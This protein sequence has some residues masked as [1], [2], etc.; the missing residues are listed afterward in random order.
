MRSTVSPISTKSE[1][2]A[3]ASLSD[4]VRARSS[5]GRVSAIRISRYCFTAFVLILAFLATTAV[6]LVG[7]HPEA[8]DPN[9]AIPPSWAF[10]V[11][12]G[13]YT[14]QQQTE[15][16]ISEMQKRGYPIDAY[17]IDSW[18][19]DWKNKGRGPAKYLD[20][21]ADTE[22]YPDMKRLWGFMRA[23]NIKSGIWVWNAILKTGNED[24]FEEFQS[25]GLFKRVFV[26]RDSWHNGGKTTILND[27][28][29]K[30][31]GTVCGDIDFSNPE[32]VALF[33]TKMRH[34]FDEGVDFLKLDRT[35]ELGVVREM[36]KMTAEMGKETAGRG[37]VFS[38]SGGIKDPEYKSYPPKWTDD[39]RSTWKFEGAEDRFS[40]WL[41][42]VGFEENLAFYTD[43]ANPRSGI[44]FLAN[45]TAG[46][47]APL[48]GKSDEELYIR[49]MQ[50]SL[51]LPLTTF[52]SQP[53][54]S[55]GNIPF[56]VSARADEVF[57]KYST[58]KMELFPYIYSAA[59]A[60]RIEG[61]NPV[62]PSETGKYQYYLGRDILVAPVYL[63]GARSRSVA[64]P[65]GTDWVDFDSGE[66]FAGGN[67]FE[68]VANLEKIP[69]FVRNGAVIPTRSFARSI[70]TGTNDVLTLS[71]YGSG[72]G[73]TN[74][75]E[76]DGR[77]DQYKNG[78]YSVIKI[79]RTAGSGDEKLIIRK[80]IGRYRGMSLIRKI[81]LVFHGGTRVKGVRIDGANATLSNSNG[82]HLTRTKKISL[83]RDVMIEIIRGAASKGK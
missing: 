79:E 82:I 33:R 15:V 42:K 59:H 23:R 43:A 7:E 14:N 22:S 17:W 56:R 66:G 68:V 19:W 57:R 49:W 27:Q 61:V 39:T 48:D 63:S 69:V 30:V 29:E 71:L 70:E 52:F 4:S 46:F 50:F 58:R 72:S 9:V 2:E 73:S 81:R 13:G 40:P 34:F 5:H 36:Y 67:T 65:M 3:D 77:S 51:H 25:K 11:I 16:L 75:V 76:D 78:G 24:V 28:G 10:G 83:E 31:E 62:R 54:N 6:G 1:C 44:P 74:I 47:A 12:Y 21:V 55:T 41:P 38:H 20:F 26:N 45:D 18:F 37:F 35:D 8:A 53:E 80:A 32:A 60:A 64:F